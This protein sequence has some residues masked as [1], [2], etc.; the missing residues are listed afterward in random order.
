MIAGLQSH[1]ELLHWHPHTHALVT[2]GAF[3][4]DREFLEV[5]ELDAERVLQLWEDRVFALLVKEE[6]ITED[7]GEDMRAW[8]HSGFSVD[9]S[10]HLPAGDRAGIERLVQYMMRCPFSLAR[11]IKVTEDGTVLYKSEKQHCRPFPDAK[12]ATLR[13]GTSRNRRPGMAG[14]RRGRRSRP[15]PRRARSWRRRAISRS[16]PCS[17]SLPSSRST[18]R[19]R[20]RI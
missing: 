6:R 20:G 10:V 15:Q 3:T 14:G 7:V 8:D 11:M 5:A 2:C 18:F 1:G 4:K 16:S 17:T 19:P 9:Q 12:S 13:Q